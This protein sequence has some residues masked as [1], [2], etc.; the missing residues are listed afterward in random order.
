MER[1]TGAISEDADSEAPDLSPSKSDTEDEEVA[2]WVKDALERRLSGQIGDTKKP[3]LHAVALDAVAGSPLLE[4][5]ST[6][7]LT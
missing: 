2:V 1:P 5:P 7:S 4:D 6:L 3:A